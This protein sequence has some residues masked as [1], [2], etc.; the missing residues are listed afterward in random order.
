MKTVFNILI[1]IMVV[2]I[3][4]VCVFRKSADKEN[5]VH[6]GS[7]SES[8]EGIRN[9]K[10]CANCFNRPVSVAYDSDTYA[11]YVS[12][13]NDVSSDLP[14][15]GYVC[16]TDLYGDIADTLKVP[17]L[18]SP[19][20]LAVKGPHLYITDL[21]RVIRFNISTDSVDLVYR[22]PGAMFLSDIVCDK[23]GVMYASDRHAGCVYRLQGDSAVVFCRDTICDNI[24]GLCISGTQLVGGCKNRI[25]AFSANGQASVVAN[26]PYSVYGIKSD[27]NDGFLVSDYV[28]NIHYVADGKT[29]VLSKRHGDANSADFE[30][31]PGQQ[32]IYM[33]TYKSNSLELYQVGGRL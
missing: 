11:L 23:R 13:L 15:S 30:Y 33:P 20:G 32:M 26:V 9:V 17:E 12:C 16:K 5:T 28:G 18:R 10:T 25:V 22:V 2:W 6:A 31:I 8:F 7:Q 3:L 4:W 1:G 21:N 29:K 27:D 19:N 14:Y 24:T